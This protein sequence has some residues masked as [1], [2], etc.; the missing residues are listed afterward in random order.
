VIRIFQPTLGQA[1]LDSIGDVFSDQWPG[2][3]PKVDAFESAFAAYVGVEREQLIALTSCTEG[4][5][6]AVAA[7]DLD[8]SSEVIVPTI[9]FIGAAHAVRAAGARLLL[10][11]VDP[12]TLNP[13]VEHL[14]R[15]FTSRT[16]AILL[17]HFGGKLPWMQQIAELA[18]ARNAVL[19]EDSAC[20][21]GGRQ[22]GTAYGTFGDIGLWSFDAMKLL[23]TGDGGMIRVSDATLR[24]K[25]ADRVNL[26][27]SISGFDAAEASRANWWEVNPPDWGRRSCMNDLTAAIGLTQLRRIDGF[28]RRRREIAQTY[29]QALGAVSWITL[30]PP[31]PNESVPYFYW[32]QTPAGARDRLAHHLKDLGIYTTFRYWPLHR[33]TLYADAGRFPG[34]D[35]ASETTLLLPVH[36]NLTDAEIAKIVEAVCAFSP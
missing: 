35:A 13:R 18:R 34:A 9:S 26:G 5:F 30:P 6:Q 20:S 29:D 24:R 32:I 7:L 19:I 23:V 2:T 1:E 36:Q 28:I 10:V 11:D 31:A 33:T 16:R 21:L 8:P 14:E 4:L 27:G 12:S 3:G 15:A 17:L 22:R 25:I